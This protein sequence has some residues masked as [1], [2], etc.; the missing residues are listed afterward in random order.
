MKR[1]GPVIV[2]LACLSFMPACF[3][4]TPTTADQ[5]QQELLEEVRRLQAEVRELKAQV[6][7][8]APA[9]R[10]AVSQEPLQE[11]ARQTTE[12]MI[13]DAN[14]RS[15]RLDMS[16][17]ATGY[18]KGKGFLISSDDGN[19]LLHPW[20]FIQV[21]NAT[22]YRENGKHGHESDTENGFE[23][24][25]MKFILDGNVLSPDL[26][27]QFIWAT[28]DTTGNLGLQDAWARYHL[29]NT[30]WALRAGPIRDPFDH[31]EIIFGTRTL[32]P[33][34][35][36]VNNVFV[37]GDGVV[38]GASVAYGY[39]TNAPIR[40]EVAFTGGERNFNTTFQTFPTNSANWGVAGRVEWKLAGK[41]EDYTQF[42]A[43]GDKQPL[44]VMGAGA[45][46]TEAG[47]TGALMH[48]V[49][50]QLNTPSGLSVYAA[51][52]GRYTRH[53]GGAPG[54]NG[55][56]S[57]AGPTANTYDSTFRLMAGYLIDQ[58]L[59]PFAR[60]EYLH[61]NKFELPASATHTVLHDF[62]V[63][64]NYYIL[65]H[66]AKF[67]AAASYLPNGSPVANTLG[68]LLVAPGGNQVIIQ[69]Q[70]QLVL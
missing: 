45:D 54:T 36:I 46:Y 26:T 39:D 51:Y 14:L 1:R 23:L 66:R 12:E 21:R 29:P 65:S 17:I 24:P 43:L 47:D 22:N 11:R 50:A 15:E 35:S 63:G 30:P 68:D 70:F 27:Y 56:L 62:T 8:N 67:S 13:R 44:L 53:N 3:A 40:S 9:T 33:E 42:T 55:G 16:S 38:K 32:T 7:A 20:A 25:R 69:A 49:D 28:N 37:N 58:R 60:Y 5:Q 57:G 6:S 59:E 52:L 10:P 48:V 18:L 4:A 19:F 2:I 41:W 61:F 64:F 31:E 34:R